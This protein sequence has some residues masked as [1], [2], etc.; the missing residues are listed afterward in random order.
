VL[1]LCAKYISLTGDLWSLGTSTLGVLKKTSGSILSVAK[2]G[3]SEISE[4]FIEE[5][6]QMQEEKLSKQRDAE[7]RSKVAPRSAASSELVR[8]LSDKH[9]YICI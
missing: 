1:S 5:S 8:F 2:S 4:A 3:I 7:D 9:V 6:K